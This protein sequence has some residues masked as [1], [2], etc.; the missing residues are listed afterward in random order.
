MEKLTDP[1]DLVPQVP[2]DWANHIVYG[3]LAGVIFWGAFRALD[4][5]FPEACAT[6]AVL[7]VAG[8]KKLWDYLHEGQSSAVCVC[9]AVVTAIWPASFA[10]VVAVG[11]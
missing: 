8:A 5:P 10:L 4:V 7:A 2:A 1:L 3:G 11:Y 9:T 6:E